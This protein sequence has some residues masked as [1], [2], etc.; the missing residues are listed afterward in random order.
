M[1]LNDE[2]SNITSKR[3]IPNAEEMTALVA[4]WIDTYYSKDDVYYRNAAEPIFNDKSNS[5]FAA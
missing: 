2:C 4:I 3:C 1:H 5:I